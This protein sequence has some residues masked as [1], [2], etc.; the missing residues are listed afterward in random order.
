MQDYI[1]RTRTKVIAGFDAANQIGNLCRE[2]GFLK[3]FL[4]TD[5][6][7]GKLEIFQTITES[8]KAKGIIFDITFGVEMEP[9]SDSIDQI[10]TEIRN[11][12][13]DAVIAV[14][15]GSTLDSAKAAC[16]MQTHEGSC[17]D[18]IYGA[19][20]TVTKPGIPCICIPTTSGSGSEVTVAAVL[21]DDE[22]QKKASISHE[23]LMPAFA[24]IDPKA[25]K[26]M[27]PGVT[28]A[29]G[30]DALTHAIE[31]YTAKNATPFSEALA[32]RAIQ[33]VGENIR[34][35]YENGED[36]EARANMAAASTMASLA[37]TN[38]GLGAVHGIAQ[39]IG[40][41]AH[42]SHGVANSV[43]LPHIMKKNYKGNLKKFEDITM[44][45]GASTEGM[46]QEEAALLSAKIVEKM[47]EDLGI[48]KTLREIHVTEEMFPK[49][50][51]ETMA[52]RFLSVNP[53]V[54]TEKDIELILKESY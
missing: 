31:S 22:K 15:G 43:M 2:N 19:S 8:L 11:F 48:P 46:T 49:I 51:E 50:V 10:I 47:G 23:Y 6:T 20:K 5:E 27:P 40:G 17:K 45:L 54:L 33:L 21:S 44:A 26:D 18:Y 29:T 39:A 4:V 16:I 34:K 9:H 53:V 25:S 32:L 35:A 30:M 7:V 3:V 38:S 36:L 52:Y 42:V 28:A 13:P 12:S 41:V 37:F 24:I 14:G 1:F